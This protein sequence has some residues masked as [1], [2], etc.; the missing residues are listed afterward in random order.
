MYILITVF[1]DVMSMYMHMYLLY[2]HQIS[3]WI[4]DQAFA[5]NMDGITFDPIR[6][7]SMSTNESVRSLTIK[8]TVR[9]N[10]TNV[11][12]IAFLSGVSSG[13]SDPAVL[14]V[15]GTCIC[16]HMYV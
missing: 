5:D 8:A 6:V 7:I 9:N 10:L 2:V 14:L 13:P 16:I 12:C 15:Q 11:S 3:F 4:N 1:A